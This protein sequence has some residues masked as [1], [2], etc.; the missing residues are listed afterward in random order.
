MVNVSGLKYMGPFRRVIALDFDGTICENEYPKI[1][2][3]KMDVIRRALKE[4]EDG[5]ALILWTCRTGELLKEAV[6]ACAA[7]GLTF[8]AVND[9]LPEWKKAWNNDPR[10]IGATGESAGG[11]MKITWKP[12]LPRS[13]LILECD[14]T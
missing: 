12:Y 1:G 7:W 14:R 4:R 3:P 5:A 8:E 9:N 10:K 6:D 2:K 13:D 11:K